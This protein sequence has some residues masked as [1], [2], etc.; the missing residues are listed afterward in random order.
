MLVRQNCSRF[1][2]AVS[3]CLLM[4]WNKP[5]EG[6]VLKVYRRKLLKKLPP[7]FF[8]SVVYSAIGNWFVRVVIFWC[9][10]YCIDNCKERV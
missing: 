6:E 2:D 9:F 1:Y 8:P 4:A 5:V 10:I 7:F 3:M